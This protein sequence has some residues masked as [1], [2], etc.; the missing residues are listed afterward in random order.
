MSGHSI[1]VSC[2]YKGW[3]R[4]DLKNKDSNTALMPAAFLGQAE[5]VKILLEEGVDLEIR[6]NVG[7]T[8]LDSAELPWEA[9]K[10][11]LNLISAFVHTPSASNW[12]T[13]RSKPDVR[14]VPNSSG[15]PESRPLDLRLFQKIVNEGQQ[16]PA[17]L[18]DQRHLRGG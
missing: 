16:L 15:R 3:A 10:G 11:I 8:A 5:T 14:F 12:I 4:L 6:S 9:A 7:T 13:M 18:C 1:P 2:L 17:A